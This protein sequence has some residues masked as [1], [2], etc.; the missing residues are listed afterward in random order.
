MGKEVVLDARE[1]LRHLA[2]PL[3]AALTAGR[4][5]RMSDVQLYAQQLVRVLEAC[6]Y[7]REAKKV[8]EAVT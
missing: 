1:V 7:M 2:R 4:E 6:G 3:A 5:G 8:E